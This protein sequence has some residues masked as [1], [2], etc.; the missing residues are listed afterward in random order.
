MVLKGLALGVGSRHI[1][2]KFMNGGPFFDGDPIIL[3]KPAHGFL[4]GDYGPFISREA[5]FLRL[6]WWEF[7]FVHQISGDV[8][9]TI[10][11]PL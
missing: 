4:K 6:F 2:I 11:K 1:A 9:K 7:T 5:G 3:W 8:I 10:A